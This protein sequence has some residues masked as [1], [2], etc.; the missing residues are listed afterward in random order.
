MRLE[1]K[2][3]CPRQKVPFWVILHLLFY[4]IS[5]YISG[6]K[7]ETGQSNDMYTPLPRDH[8]LYK[9][10]MERSDIQKA[11]MTPKFLDAM[12]DLED[13]KATI[14]DFSDD[15]EIGPIL[16]QLSKAI[17]KF[18]SQSWPRVAMEIDSHEVTK[19]L[20]TCSQVSALY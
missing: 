16:F 4:L 9:L 15:S 20:N 3:F 5:C 7:Q 18:S 6:D 2:E 12:R 19:T 11:L 14:V 8:A 10:V 13:K 17:Q 1:I